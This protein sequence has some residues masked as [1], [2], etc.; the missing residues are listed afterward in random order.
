MLRLHG[1]HPA[2]AYHYQCRLIKHGSHEAGPV[3]ESDRSPYFANGEVKPRHAVPA[4][5]PSGLISVAYLPPRDMLD[6]VIAAF[7][8]SRPDLLLKISELGVSFAFVTPSLNTISRASMRSTLFSV[9]LGSTCPIVSSAPRH[10]HS[11]DIVILILLFCLS[12]F[13]ILASN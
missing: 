1:K 11:P 12:S 4:A 5:Y 8:A 2:I 3:F 7:S 6:A 10:R 13:S 9:F